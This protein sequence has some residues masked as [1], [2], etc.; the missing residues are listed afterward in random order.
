MGGILMAAAESIPDRIGRVTLPA[1]PPLAATYVA[2]RLA[3]PAAMTAGFVLPAQWIGMDG[4]SSATPLAALQGGATLHETWQLFFGVRSGAMGE[5]CVAAVLLGAGYLLVRRRLRL[6]APAC[7]L[8][9][10][11]FLSWLGWN[12]PLYG[13]L[14]GAPLLAAVLLA[15]EALL[16]PAWADQVTAGVTAGGV[17]ALVRGWGFW[18]DGTAVGLL[19]AF[20]AVYARPYVWKLLRRIP[21]NRIL[22]FF[23][24]KKNNS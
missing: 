7:M 15:D 1:L 22:H 17:T 21:W 18:A 9:T 14:A 16:P 13:L 5:L 10:L 19:A 6:I 8:A 3:F 23:I 24:K 4:V 11:S 20:V 2:L 12:S